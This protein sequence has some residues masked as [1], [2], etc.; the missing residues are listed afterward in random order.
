[1]TDLV[2]S[3]DRNFVLTASVANATTTVFSSS[4]NS[5]TLLAAANPSRVGAAI[6]NTADKPMYVKF[7]ATATSSSH[8][9]KILAGGYYEF[10]APCYNGIV[11]AIWDATPTGSFSVTEVKA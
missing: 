10:P 3:R 1:M 7:G 5:I 4:T 2:F 6:M 9:V 11:D 8:I